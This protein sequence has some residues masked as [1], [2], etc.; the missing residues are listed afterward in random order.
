MQKEVIGYKQ[1]DNP[2][3][4]N[5]I[6]LQGDEMKGDGHLSEEESCGSSHVQLNDVRLK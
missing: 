5:R 2:V 1:N 6:K 3:S 4:H